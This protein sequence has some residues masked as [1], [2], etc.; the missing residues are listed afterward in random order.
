MLDPK[1]LLE[2][3][4]I[5]SGRAEDEEHGFRFG[6]L[7]R[8]QNAA[9]ETINQAI[10]NVNCHWVYNECADEDLANEQPISRAERHKIFMQA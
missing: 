4:D 5:A 3:H 1:L 6:V 7:V 9:M 8:A 2:M 10:G